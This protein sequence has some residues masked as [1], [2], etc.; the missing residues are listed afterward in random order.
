MIVEFGFC[1]GILIGAITTWLVIKLRSIKN[2]RT[3]S[4]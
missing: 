4:K 1:D 2:G 3:R